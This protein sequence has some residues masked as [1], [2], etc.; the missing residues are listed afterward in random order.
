MI[1]V[2]VILVLIFSAF[3]MIGDF[4]AEE[5]MVA[6]AALTT[7]SVI[8]IEGDL[9]FSAANGV[10]NPGATGTA[11]NPYIIKDRNIDGAGWGAFIDR[12]G[13]KEQSYILEY[14]GGLL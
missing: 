9:D 10:S 3:V 12:Y 13:E 8:R 2:V 7:H 5:P 14:G 11:S 4:G 6:S 1:S